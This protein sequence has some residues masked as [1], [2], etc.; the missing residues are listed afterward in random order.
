MLQSKKAGK[1]NEIGAYG[2]EIA[3]TFLMERNFVFLEQ[4]FL[5]KLGEIDLIMEKE[6]VIHFVEVK[7]VSFATQQ[8][9]KAS[10]GDT[11]RPEEQFTQDKYRKLSNT[12]DTWLLKE[13]YEGKYQLDLLTVRLILTE[14]Y[15][16]VQYFE[17]V[18]V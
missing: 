16:E 9:L 5:Q 1:K 6:G 8:T 17:A 18:N 14:K 3:K 13:S 7:T 4:N 2:E 12:I 11:Y 15:A 10:Y